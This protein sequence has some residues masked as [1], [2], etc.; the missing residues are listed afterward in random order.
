MRILTIRLKNLNSLVGEW[1]IDLT[2][3]AYISDGIFTISGPTGAGKT[4]ILDAICLALYGRTP[5]LNKVTKSGNDIL[6]RHTGECFAEV[7]FETPAGTY[8]CHWSQHRSRKKPDGELQ[9]P[10]HEISDAN[11]GAVLETKILEVARLIETITGMDFNRFTRSMLLAQGGFAVFLEAAPDERSPILE[12]I[13]G[14]EIY[15]QISIRVHEC[16]AQE[17]KKLDTLTVQLSGITLLSDA[18]EQALQK[19]QVSKEHQEAALAQHIQQHQ[20]ALAWR[21]GIARLEQELHTLA[22][23]QQ[24]WEQ[25]RDAFQPQNFR[26]TRAETALELQADFRELTAL[27]KQRDTAQ[28]TVTDSL[29]EL[30][31]LEHALQEASAQCTHLQQNMVQAKEA[32]ATLAI[33]L[34]EVRR[35]DSTIAIS[36]QARKTKQDALASKRKEYAT[37]NRTYQTECTALQNNRL[38]LQDI[39]RQIAATQAD[40]SLTERLSGIN[41]T[42]ALLRKLHAQEDEKR[43]VHAQ[44][45]H[46]IRTTTDLWNT[47]VTEVQ[48]IVTLSEA[49]QQTLVAKQHELAAVLGDQ[50]LSA[51]R[52]Q[53]STLTARKMHDESRL[54]AARSRK[55]SQQAIQQW[56]AQC[57]ALQQASAQL[58]AHITR[59][60][61]EIESSEREQALLETQLALLQKI[62]SLEAERQKLHDGTPCPLCGATEHPFAA[63]NTPQIDAT[64]AQASALRAHGKAL[65]KSLMEANIQHTQLQKDISYGVE[66]SIEE[67]H[68]IAKIDREFAQD[69]LLSATETT[70]DQLA[71][72][73]TETITALERCTATIQTAEAKEREISTVRT[74]LEMAKSAQATAELQAKQHENAKQAAEES[75]SRIATERES[76]R[77]HRE[78]EW[79]EL[80]C[81]LSPYQ[82]GAITLEALPRLQQSLLKR[83][84]QWIENQKMC[85][86]LQQTIVI[87]EERTQQQAAQLQTNFEAIERDEASLRQHEQEHHALETER[88][89][90]FGTKQAD[91]EEHRSS[92]LLE[93]A[94]QKY[95]QAQKGFHEVSQQ[96]ALLQSR[97]AESHANVETFTAQLVSAEA[98]FLTHATA[99]GF[100]SEA[101]Y[102]AAL[103]PNEERQTLAKQ[104]KML[105]E[106][107]NVLRTQQQEKILLRD[108]EQAKTI[109]TLSVEALQVALTTASD[110]QKELQQAMGALR[111]QL[112]EHALRQVQQREQLAAIA[113][114]QQECQRWGR[115][116][117]LIGSADGKKYRNFA[118]GLT[119]E[120]M[121][122]YANQQ[123]KKMSERY[124]L[125]RD[126]LQPLELNVIDAYQ[127]G[128]IR[129][130]KNLS[131]GEGFLVSLSL[132]LGLSNMA[133]KNVRVDSLFL[134][135]GFGT[136][137]AE[138]LDTALETLA[139]LQQDGKIIGLISHIPAL[140]ERIATQIEVTPLT[141]GKSHIHGPGCRQVV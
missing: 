110:Q 39:Q 137:D 117:D 86:S 130:T 6:S 112:R 121:I 77:Q 127:A 7:T 140:K 135:E 31:K 50:D 128:E 136:L 35:L 123:L 109:T 27:R 51:W 126:P 63:G 40:E 96:S 122:S 124:L 108:S 4:T 107:G 58:A 120:M 1:E 84:T 73:L 88:V 60:T 56:Q 102:Q 81:A 45:E 54:S 44:A 53:W 106:A 23:E 47:A 99:L 116:H 21:Q 52:T 133:S 8:C 64:A 97:I 26:L 42:I 66:R 94:E 114:Q 141:G 71:K 111:Q 95:Q 72:R 87:L 101:D 74:A 82:P 113:L 34:R 16:K 33:Q 134:D 49:Q 9:P 98:S 119:F 24:Q 17:Q 79:N 85:A 20:H 115:L 14:T 22:T 25:R 36:D 38:A 76:L 105:E 10:K 32:Q 12:Q 30:P 68:N 57:A 138:A 48:K 3:P 15:S 92:A 59:L 70:P 69:D 125:L 67:Q 118:Q 13:T 5:R 132:A 19:E 29:A 103:L 93:T 129:S 2:N 131:G 75:C 43:L 37:R 139:G 89:T 41:G 91:A 80:R 62:E 83:R 55:E 28:Q 100:S 11:S 78:A 61:A 18:D 46:T 65:Q 90:L 104:A